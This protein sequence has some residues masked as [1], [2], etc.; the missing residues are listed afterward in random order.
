MPECALNLAQAA[1]YLALAPKSN[2]ADQAIAARARRRPRARRR[3][4]ARLPARRPLPGRKKLGR[5][6][7]YDY[8]HDEPGG[9]SDQPL[10]PEG[11][12]GERFYEPTD[13]GFEAELRRR[14]EQLRKRLAT[15]ARRN[16]RSGGGCFSR[17]N[18]FRMCQGGRCRDRRTR[19]WGSP[20][21]APCSAPR[22]CGGDVAGK[23]R[24]G[25]R[26]H[27]GH[28]TGATSRPRSR[29]STPSI[30]WVAAR[31]QP[32]P[33]SGRGR[34]GRDRA[35]GRGSIDDQRR[36]A[37]ASAGVRR[38]RRPRRGPGSDTA[39][40]GD[41]SGRDRHAALPTRSRR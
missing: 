5:G 39:A 13:R 36:P 25:T 16:L 9:V 40:A 30:E 37:A 15:A 6:V 38:R 33:D 22:Y 7:G 28:T 35:S 1:A 21:R 41:E 29:S 32:G 3:A 17:C 14:L 18:L 31:R 10:L 12:E 8:P 26:V 27:R 4:A 11:L 20:A 19:D 24:Q 34:D 2:A 23:R